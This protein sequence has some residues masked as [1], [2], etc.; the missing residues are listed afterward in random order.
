MYLVKNKKSPN[1]QIVYFVNKN[2]TTV[3][4]KTKIKKEA[5]DYLK[6]FRISLN[7][8]EEEGI[9]ET[10]EPQQNIYLS[11]FR[12]EYLEY[13]NS[14]KSKHYISSI[15]LSFRQLESFLGDS[16]L[17]NINVR[18]L[19]KFITSTFARTQTGAH[20][21]YRTLKAAFT[22]AVAWEYMKENPLT[23]IKFPKVSKSLPVFISVDEFKI[24]H[25][26]VKEQYLKDLYAVAF[27]TGMR[28][29]ELINMKSNWIDLS[30]NIITI[31]NDESFQTKSK[32]ERI[33]PFNK[34]LRDIFLR[35]ISKKD[36]SKN[37]K[38]VFARLGNVKLKGDYVSKKLKKVIRTIGL[39][40]KIHFHTLRHSFASMLVQKGV[41]LYVVKE[42]LGHE[43]LSTTQIYSHLKAQNLFDAVSMLK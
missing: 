39:N 22:K 31:K 32:K 17:N 15:A 27:Y 13:V 38:I 26:Q 19:D 25:S 6:R 2:R 1:Y 20:L 35:Y 43:D 24:I 40:D 16:P 37:N 41:S 33:I 5:E 28:R 36:I 42:L 18:A 10:K 11:D 21:Y 14:I 4:T 34:N 3:S 23:K 9:G 7:K 30:K 12:T 29:G 8:N